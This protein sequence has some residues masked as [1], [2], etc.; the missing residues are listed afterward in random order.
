MSENKALLRA[1]MRSKTANVEFKPY[2]FPI[3]IPELRP[4]VV[5]AGTTAPIAMD[6]INYSYLNN[7][8][9]GKGF[10]G[11]PYLAQLSTRAEFMRLA[12]SLSTELTRGGISLTSKQDDGNDNSYKIKAIDAEFKRLKVIPAML[13]TAINE[14]YFG[15][16]QM[17]I[18]IDGAKSNKPLIISK[19]T[20][21]KGKLNRIG[22]IE[23][24]WTTPSMYNASDPTAANFYQPT[25]WYCMGKKIHASRL[26][27]VVTRPLP[28]ILKP[29]YNFSGMSLSQMAESYVD[30]WLRTRQSVSDLINQFSI[31][32]LAT[33]MS[34]ILQS[35]EGADPDAGD[36]L[37]ARADLFTALRSNKGLMLLDKEHEELQQINTPLSGLDA[38]QA[39]AQEQMCSVSRIPAIVFT[40]I[41]PGGLNA[42]SEGE[43][44][45]FYDWI[46]SQQDA[47]WREPLE[48]IL[49]LVQLSLFEE[50]DD[51]IG[52]E[53][54]P[55][56]QM[57]PSEKAD[58]RLKDMQTDTGYLGANVLD[59]QEVRE[60]LARDPES[61]YDSI[62]TSVELVPPNP[63]PL[64]D[65]GDQSS[66]NVDDESNDPFAKDGWITVKPNG[67]D[68]KGAHVEID[69]EGKI[70]AGMGGKFNGK[71]IDEI[72][73]KASPEKDLTKMNNSSKVESQSINSET[74]KMK[75]GQISYTFPKDF[76]IAEMQGRT[77]EG[78]I[79]ARTTGKF[80]DPLDAVRFPL[81]KSKSGQVIV[82]R[83]A[84]KPEL[85][86]A[87][88]DHLES[89]AEAKA[90]AK[91]DKEAFAK[92]PRGMYAKLKE[93]E[94]NAYDPDNF[95]GSAKWKYHKQLADKVSEFEAAN[96]ELMA[97]LKAEKAA[98]ESKRYNELSDFVKNGS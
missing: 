85:E 15:R 56:Q 34:S 22:S 53:F 61:G 86:A 12:M 74:P 2:E 77:V 89:E 98:K 87:L 58:I 94:Y 28:D 30:N 83:V 6:D 45:V 52:L 96:P 1:V 46:K 49:K 66:N 19:N 54:V 72:K 47:Y 88:K 41:S 20:I 31:T 35:A 67:P 29:A 68:N 5:P 62:D 33:E 26:L 73:D 84:G 21:G 59:G 64:G 97:E 95:P 81:E 17:Y 25:E 39:Q 8:Y 55:L 79:F 92:T 7:A 63:D 11:Y 10:P 60:K 14:C 70:T 78:G 37:L 42:N 90:K 40:G 38:L 51:D 82:A 57:T 36:N 16:G 3:Q 50:I 44:K 27:T 24:I 43:L 76:P 71:K 4:G 80:S 13:Q 75:N 69:G 32:V 91:A 93:A 23:P 18:E 48:V 9:C 65:G